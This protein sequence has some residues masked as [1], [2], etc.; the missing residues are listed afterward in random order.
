MND[1]IGLNFL[2]VILAYVNRGAIWWIFVAVCVVFVVFTSV[3][4]FHWERYGRNNLI[5][6]L[7][8][9]VYLVVSVQIVSL[10]YS[11]IISFLNH[12]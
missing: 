3:L 5:I 6:I 2:P 9:V 1:S 7:A 10:A 12:A 11:S 4:V 8:E